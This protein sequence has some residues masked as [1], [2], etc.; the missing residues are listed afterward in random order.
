MSADAPWAAVVAAVAAWAAESGVELRDTIVLLPY[1]QLLAVARRA[2]GAAGGWVPRIETTR[3][4]ARAVGPAEPPAPGQV[5]F[6][7]AL[8]RIVAARMLRS[9]AWGAAWARADAGGFSQAVAAVVDTAHALAEAAHALP[10]DHRDEHWQRARALLSLQGMA[11]AAPGARERALGRLALEWAAAAPPPGTDRLFDLEPAGWVVLQVGGAEALARSLIDHA[12]PATPCLWLDADVDAATPF[13]D[14]PAATLCRIERCDDFEAEAWRCAARVLRHLSLGEQPVALVAQDRLLVR[15]VRALLARE[16]AALHDETGWKL[17]TTRAGAGM[18][19][20]LTCARDDASTDDWLEW[21]KCCAAASAE[22]RRWVPGL[23]EAL[24]SLEQSLRAQKLRLARDVSMDRLST[25]PA[26]LWQAAHSVLQPWTQATRRSGTGWIELLRATLRATG[27]L[28]ALEADDAGRQVLA[29]LHLDAAGLPAGSGLAGEM[30]DVDEFTDWL[31]SVLELAP[32][33]PPLAGPAQVVVTPLARAVLRPF[34][35][36]VFPGADQRHFGAPSQATGL[37]SDAECRALGLPDRAARRDD[38]VRAFAQLLRCPRVSLLYRASDGGEPQCASP[39]VELLRLALHRQRG[40]DGAWP[41]DDPFLPQ[42]LQ[43]TPQARP[44]PAAPALLPQRL[45][46][47]ACEALRAC[48]YR[49]FALRML[50]LSAPEEL[51]ADLE[52]REYGTWLHAV[53]QR[54]HVER[55]APDAFDA[56]ADRLHA[57]A[58]EVAQEQ[59]LEQAD[60]LPFSATF[61]RLVPRYL[62]WLHE[63]DADGALWLDAELSRTVQPPGWGAVQMHGVIDRVDCVNSRG[64]PVT[65]LID[66]KTGS[67]QALRDAIKQGEDTQLP[68]YAALMAGQSEAPGDFSALYL[69][70]DESDKVREVPHPG[71]QESAAAL[72][73]GIGHD[74]ARLAGGAALPA[75]GEGSAC[76]HCDAR[77]LCRRDHWPPLVEDAG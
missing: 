44:R 24:D 53:L 55:I 29:A 25:R 51:D 69:M 37:L 16:G 74:L 64:V 42:T 8:D 1:A 70:L 3:S 40:A 33:L 45:S 77:G 34:A 7:V 46:A 39:W 38:Q 41:P 26:A 49:F 28:A 32:F 10:P 60:L 18:R 66:Y 23:P 35:A 56:E 30:L 13:A 63:R 61:A 6:D 5:S 75:L 50:R 52:K 11:D 4:L 57:I 2:F 71:V 27:Q 47:S 72:V 43:P 59:G 36:I 31:D 19:S 17:S 62:A 67:S 54:F 65:Q 12:A 73:D 76:D 21:L 9:L 48:P 22:A 20:V 58:R 15:R 14:L 68:F